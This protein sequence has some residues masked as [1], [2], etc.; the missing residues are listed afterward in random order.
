MYGEPQILPAVTGPLVTV[1]TAAVLPAT[2]AD[3]IT[4]AA[5]AVAAGLVTWGAVYFFKVVRG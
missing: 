3:F 2:G 4:T 5:T 1:G